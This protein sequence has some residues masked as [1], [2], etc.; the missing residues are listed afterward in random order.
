MTGK[1][2]SVTTTRT[3]ETMGKSPMLA[4]STTEYQG[5]TA[6]ICL[7]SGNTRLDADDGAS[8]REG[9]NG[10]IIPIERKCLGEHTTKHVR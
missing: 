7:A 5:H 2:T 8:C 1:N 4:V 6:H 3:T 9:P 10:N